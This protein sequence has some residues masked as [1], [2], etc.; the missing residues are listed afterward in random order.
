VIAVT[1]TNG[2]ILIFASSS[3]AYFCL[4]DLSGKLL[5]VFKAEPGKQETAATVSEVQARFEEEI[6]FWRT[7]L[8]A[9]E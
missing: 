8:G 4:T 1:D 6:V 7:Y 2:I 5:R 3:V 9:V